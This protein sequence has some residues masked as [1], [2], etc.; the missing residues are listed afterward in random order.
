MTDPSSIFKILFG[1]ASALKII[2]IKEKLDNWC[3]SDN[4][5]EINDLVY[6]TLVKSII[7]SD[8]EPY[9]K[10]TL[11]GIFSTNRAQLIQRIQNI[12]DQ[13]SEISS[14]FDPMF[15][16]QFIQA[17]ED[18]ILNGDYE[19]EIS[20]CKS[21][22]ASLMKSFS[23]QLNDDRSDSQGIHILIAQCTEIANSIRNIDAKLDQIKTT[24]YNNH[25]SLRSI[26]SSSLK[27]TVLDLVKDDVNDT[28]ELIK[29][30]DYESSIKILKGILDRLEKHDITDQKIYRT[31][32]TNIAFCYNSIQ[33]FGEYYKYTLKILEYGEP[34]ASTLLNT[35]WAYI[36][37]EQSD[38]AKV[39]YDTLI[40]KYKGSE[41]YYSVILDEVE[42]LDEKSKGII[43]KAKLLFP[44]SP[45]I[46][47]RIGLIYLKNEMLDLYSTQMDKTVELHPDSLIRIGRIHAFNIHSRIYNTV[48]LGSPIELNEDDKEKLQK[49]LLLYN[50][51]WDK[52]KK[53]SSA[54]YHVFDLIHMSNIYG[55]L[56]DKENSIKYL[57]YAQELHGS[58]IVLSRL[59][60]WFYRENNYEKALEYGK[61]ISS[62]ASSEMH[63]AIIVY[64]L[65]LANGTNEQAKKGLQDIDKFIE[66]HSDSHRLKFLKG[67]L[68]IAN[69]H[70]EEALEYAK[71]LQII[72]PTNANY[73]VLEARI[74][75]NLQ[76]RQEASESVKTAIEITNAGG[77]VEKGE[78]LRQLWEL[79]EYSLL[80]QES[81]KVEEVNLDLFEL[82]CYEQSLI[83][84]E[85]DKK[86]ILFYQRMINRFQ[87]KYFSYNYCLLLEKYRDY[88]SA[89]DVCIE[90]LNRDKNDKISRIDYCQ[91]LVKTGN[92]EMASKVNLDIDVLELN[93]IYFQKLHTQLIF[94]KRIDQVVNNLYLKYRSNFDAACCDSIMQSF[95]ALNL[96]KEDI[97][98]NV[99]KPNTSI[100]IR[101]ILS[102]NVRELVLRKY[103]ST[104]TNKH[105][106]I[107]PGDSIYESCI[108]KELGFRFIVKSNNGILPEEEYEVVEIHSLGKYLFDKAMIANDSIHKENSNFYTFQ[109]TDDKSVFSFLDK[110]VGLDKDV[111]PPEDESKPFKSYLNLNFPSGLIA[112]HYNIHSFVFHYTVLKKYGSFPNRPNEY[113]NDIISGLKTNNNVSYCVDL[114]GI[115]SLYRSRTK[116]KDVKVYVSQSTIDLIRLLIYNN[117]A[118]QKNSLGFR[119]HDTRE[120]LLEATHVFLTDMF[121]EL[122]KVLNWII[123]NLQTPLSSLVRLDYTKEYISKFESVL[124]PSILDTF[125]LAR[126]YGMIVISDEYVSKHIEIVEAKKWMITS[127]MFSSIIK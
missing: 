34:S 69:N 119:I 1:S 98:L 63:D 76:S 85:A 9:I 39:Q 67:I 11:R 117:G 112:Q 110:M 127:Q 56:N 4:V 24:V 96:K 5:S 16:S 25:L 87:Y 121:K 95:V 104:A 53:T 82:Q 92:I 93:P 86:R 27:K 6:D 30:H 3:K 64:L 31:V 13:T 99:I 120:I 109:G 55:A 83:A 8:L 66:Q 78:L 26:E 7:S 15:E 88:E 71:E 49:S 43:S 33:K 62:F 57:Q 36:A 22:F 114:T 108:G 74:H 18:V 59:M 37:L 105:D 81:E 19:I 32:Y 72:H 17:L 42:N 68:L 113:K 46:A 14:V 20:K 54:K 77:K 12:V 29:N 41:E 123:E 51:I 122:P 44:E 97:F 47:F 101:N 126:K 2:N 40:N 115:L 84:I 52:V 73:H 50:A 60:L 111:K 100:L 107:N 94:L 103:P 79:D 48:K 102:Q 118:F 80:I 38:K 116:I 70:N 75:L 89:I 90:I 28:I 65:I 23:A 35:Y 61:Q 58:D 10:T 45:E 125:L 91:L 124:D 106:E 21:I